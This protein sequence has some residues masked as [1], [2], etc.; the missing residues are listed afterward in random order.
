[1]Q[2]GHSRGLAATLYRSRPTNEENTTKV[3]HGLDSASLKNAKLSSSSNNGLVGSI[4]YVLGLGDTFSSVRAFFGTFK[5]VSFRSKASSEFSAN[6][7]WLVEMA[8]AR[9]F[10]TNVFDP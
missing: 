1:M 5:F 6:R 4:C 7:L 2:L 9:S 8:Q 3:A 10:W